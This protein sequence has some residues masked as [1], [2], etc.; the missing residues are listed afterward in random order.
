M[1]FIPILCDVAFNPRQARS[2]GIYEQRPRRWAITP[3][4]YKERG[5]GL[6]FD[7]QYTILFLCRNE[8]LDFSNETL[9]VSN[10]TLDFSNENLDVISKT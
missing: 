10:E 8:T 3:L 4:P 7:L 6:G 2:L 9:D 5:W 1:N